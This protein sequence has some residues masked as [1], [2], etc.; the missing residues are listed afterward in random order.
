[1]G[2]EGTE[3]DG[4]GAEARA[5][6]VRQAGKRG[7]ANRNWA[8]TVRGSPEAFLP[9]HE[10]TSEYSVDR[11]EGVAGAGGRLCGRSECADPQLDALAAVRPSLLI[12]Y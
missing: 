5:F 12:G 1:M 11:H 7:L 10:I 2:A 4:A 6:E 3:G 8:R 9:T